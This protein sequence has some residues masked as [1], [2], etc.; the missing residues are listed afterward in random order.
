MWHAWR[1]EKSVQNLVRKPEV[2]PKCRWED[3]IKMDL[4]ETECECGL[5][6]SDS[7]LGLIVGLCEHSKESLGSIKGRAAEQ[8]LATEEGLLHQLSL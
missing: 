5:D 4:K 6:S 7:G 3:N 1:D 2:I 8:L